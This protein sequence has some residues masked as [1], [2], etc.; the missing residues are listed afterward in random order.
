M[1]EATSVTG[2]CM[3]RRM[4]QPN[5]AGRPP[6]RSPEPYEIRGHHLPRKRAVPN[7]PL[8]KRLVI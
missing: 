6:G 3:R 2:T 8:P 4:N 7:Q 5:Q 1:R